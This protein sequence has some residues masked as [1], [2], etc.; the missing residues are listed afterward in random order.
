MEE[1]RMLSTT[2]QSSTE[3]ART[4]FNTVRKGGL[5]PQ[6]VRSHLETVAR[7]V[8]HLESR[9]RDLQEQLSEAMRRAANPTFDEATLAAALGAQ[10]AAILRS[11]HEEA[12]RVTAEAQERSALLFSE[13]QKRAANHL[14]EAQERAGAMLTEAEHAAA[15]IDQ[16]ARLA[17]ER[18]IESAKVNGDAL[19]D[20]GREQGR[21]IVEQANEAR[22]HVL[23]DLAV[24]RKALHIQ[25]DQLRAARDAMNTFVAGVRDQVD[26]L[27]DNINGSDE[28]ARAAALEALRVRPPSRELTEEE[29]LAGT[30]LRHV[31]EA[32]LQVV[33]ASS[34]VTHLEPVTAPVQ[35]APLAAPTP[36]SASV[37]GHDDESFVDDDGAG[38]DVVNEIFARLRKATLEE[39]GA[40]PSAPPPK[41]SSAPT[42]PE[43][44]LDE[45]FA[46]RDRAIDESL[47]VLTR[48]V[49]RALQDDQNITLERLRDVKGPITA[50]LE[51]ELEQR[52][53]YAE[54]AVDALA[55]ATAAGMQF[56]LDEAGATSEG[57]ARAEIEDCAQDL[58]V[59]I[60]LALRK[61]ILADGNGDAAERA[62]AAYKEWRGARVERL[63]TDAARRA[64][65]LGVATACA[66][67][68][69]RFLPAPNDSP[70]DACALDATAPPRPAGQVFPS[71]S[72]Y[73]PLH[74]GC[75]CTV[76]PA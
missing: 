23:N 64:F 34:A 45:L 41:K 66:G 71:G 16:E 62:N 61:R 36:A 10:S 44:P 55:D 13:S 73:P 1:R 60:V 51:D 27:L 49:K 68:L 8:G 76:V 28:A 69:L 11:A 72:A 37:G 40:T 30:P 48:K 32:Q 6:E 70:C 39:R 53:R 5:D 65:H 38:T 4:N 7:E 67:R 74:A 24:K 21:A 19:V 18:L 22:R 14:I 63:C 75:A 33:A 35:A 31:P 42:K 59:T 57:Q 26:A 3:I 15:Q 17:A 50:E 2:R 58:A 9:I 12:G 47:S 54:A 52:R 29:L 43:T 56:A 46:R 20:R 25:I